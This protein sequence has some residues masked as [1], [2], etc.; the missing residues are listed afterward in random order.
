MQ[1]LINNVFHEFPT[2]SLTLAFHGGGTERICELAFILVFKTENNAV[3]DTQEKV[4]IE[5]HTCYF[6]DFSVEV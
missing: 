6:M 5:I 2:I 1:L 3:K 4:N